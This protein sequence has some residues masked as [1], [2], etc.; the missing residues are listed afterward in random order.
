M[1]TPRPWVQYLKRGQAVTS[2]AAGETR[3]RSTLTQ[4]KEYVMPTETEWAE[5]FYDREMEL[6]E[7]LEALCDDE[8]Y[9]YYHSGELG[10]QEPWEY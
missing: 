5:L 7:E 4:T 3:P 10:P 6:A 2:M 9:C 8:Y 1:T